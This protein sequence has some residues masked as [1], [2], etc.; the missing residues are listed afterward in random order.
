MNVTRRFSH[1]RCSV[2]RMSK[3]YHFSCK[4]QGSS[5][6]DWPSRSSWEKDN[7]RSFKLGLKS[8]SCK[9][10]PTLK[11]TAD[12]SMTGTQPR[13]NCLHSDQSTNRFNKNAGNFRIHSNWLNTHRS[14]LNLTYQPYHHNL[15]V[16]S[17]L[18]DSWKRNNISYK[19]KVVHRSI[20]YSCIKSSKRRTI[21]SWQICSWT[22]HVCMGRWRMLLKGRN[23]LI[24]RSK[25]CRGMSTSCFMSWRKETCKISSTEPR[26]GCKCRK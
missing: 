4:N 3:R 2:N 13:R 5:M 25:G 26:S 14:N 20:L 6:P 15:Q 10:T 19:N 23:S 16:S 8:C 12:W 9:Q 7:L 22:I 1:S 17:H 18:I 21:S 24:L 11:T